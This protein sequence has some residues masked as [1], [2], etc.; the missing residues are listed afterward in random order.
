[1]REIAWG[2]VSRG[3]RDWILLRFQT[4][5]RKMI[6]GQCY[7][8]GL[9]DVEERV[10]IPIDQSSVTQ[11]YRIGDRES[12]LKPL[13]NKSS[14]SWSMGRTQF[15]KIFQFKD[16]NQAFSF[17]TRVALLAEKM[18]HHPEWF[19]VYNKV[20]VTLW[21]HDVQGLSQRDIKMATFME[22]VAASLAA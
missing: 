12:H 13:F 10:A 9:I 2:R 15:T 16:F 5:V 7:Y 8:M 20:K 3:Q 4:S 6:K 22:T 19:N 11:T 17:M 14:G 21:S 18:D 1:A